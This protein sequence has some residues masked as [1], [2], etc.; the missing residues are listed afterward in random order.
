MRH[1]IRCSIME[2]DGS[3]AGMSV[4]VRLLVSYSTCARFYL[5]SLND[6]LSLV[7]GCA[8]EATETAEER[9]AS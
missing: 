9:D 6:L 4:Y 5:E 2:F 1:F 3:R 8:T 7:V